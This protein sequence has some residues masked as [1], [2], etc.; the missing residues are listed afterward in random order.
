MR[1]LSFQTPLS[2]GH[3]ILASD[4]P[5]LIVEVDLSL[6]FEVVEG[7]FLAFLLYDHQ[8]FV[9]GLI[10]VSLKHGVYLVLQ[11]QMLAQRLLFNLQEI[12]LLLSA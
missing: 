12:F 4:C 2:F 9:E 11:S 5:L 1:H 8:L 6:H 10:S 3:R 7:L